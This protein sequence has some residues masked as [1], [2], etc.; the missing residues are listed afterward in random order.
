MTWTVV[1]ADDDPDILG[2]V[3]IAVKRA[4]LTLAATA[5]DGDRALDTIRELVPDLAILDVS[6]PGMSGLE[7]C[8]L[9]REDPALDDVRL[10]VLSASVDESARSVA[11]EAGADHFLSK[12]F[13]IRELT[14]WLAAGKEPR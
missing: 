1:C 2:L 7:V 10:A 8:R 11:L 9:V 13:G 14:A 5:P 12:P 3:T 4:G 6:M